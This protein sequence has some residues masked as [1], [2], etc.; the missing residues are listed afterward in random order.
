MDSKGICLLFY[1][2]WTRKQKVKVLLPSPSCT[3]PFLQSL[4]VNWGILPPGRFHWPFLS[5]D[6]SPTQRQHAFAGHNYDLYSERMNYRTGCSP[7]MRVLRC[8][9][10]HDFIDLPYQKFSLGMAG[11]GKCG[12]WS[13]L[14]HFWGTEARTAR[15]RMVLRERDSGRLGAVFLCLHLDGQ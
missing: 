8:Y 3:W 7:G 15:A 1:T 6:N 5:W 4:V 2:A 9:Q 11:R 10:C 13:S 14:C 12:C